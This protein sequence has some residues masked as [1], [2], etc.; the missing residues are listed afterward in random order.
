[1]ISRL[2]AARAA[3]AISILAAALALVGCQSRTA[4]ERNPRPGTWTVVDAEARDVPPAHDATARDLA[5]PRD[6]A[7]RDAAPR[8]AAL[9]DAALRDAARADGRGDASGTARDAAGRDVAARDASPD[10]GPTFCGPR[11]F[12]CSPYACDV[13]AAQCKTFCTS[14]D[15]CLPGKPCVN[16][17]CGPNDNQYCTVDEECL[18]G[19]C[20]VVCCATAC[21][22]VCHSCA[23]PGSAGV[24]FPVPAG[25]PDPQNRCPAG[26]VCGADAGCVAAPDTI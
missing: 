7:L 25:M 14:D 19:H 11:H 22:G 20:A 6:G 24:C 5:P 9:R 13:A 12:N 18:S 10:W 3:R 21:A 4:R 17:L 23:L 8:D 26:T 15:D 1:M 2:A 16:G